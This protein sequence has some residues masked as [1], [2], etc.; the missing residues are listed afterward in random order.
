M[1]RSMKAANEAV[2]KS[3]DA[4][5]QI[6]NVVL[7]NAGTARWITSN[8][9]DRE[10]LRKGKISQ[11]VNFSP[12]RKLAAVSLH[13]K[14]FIVAVGFDLN[15]DYAGLREIPL[16]G[17]H[18]TL[19]LSELEVIPTGSVSEI[20]QVVE[21]SDRHADPEYAGHEADRV[22]SL[23]PRILLLENTEKLLSWNIF[24]RLALNENQY[25]GSWVDEKL[26]NIL[27][28]VAELDGTKIP[29]KVL[30]R[31]IF[32]IDPTSFFLA[33]YRCLEAIFAYS[34]A[35]ELNGALALNLRWDVVANALEETLGWYPHEDGSL[36]KLL[37]LASEAD[38]KEISR[39]IGKYTSNVES[40]ARLAARNIYWLRNSIVHYRPSQHELSFDTYDW[41]AICATMA[42]IVL[43][44]YG[45]VD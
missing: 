24:F 10:F 32:D 33:E 25:I 6:R 34:S 7:A 9:D 38:L 5:C 30:C 22:A 45:G 2:F 29:Y 35:K 26:V 31:S 20:R 23:Y 28:M 1:S 39:M 44:V 8:N 12:R 21:Y 42:A 40:P 19:V 3:L 13:S 37:A 14:E 16:A 17:G 27:R 43:H 4:H 11:I 36:T 15:D 18:L 41:N